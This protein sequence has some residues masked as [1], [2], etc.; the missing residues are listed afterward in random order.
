LSGQRLGIGSRDDFI[1]GSFMSL[2]IQRARRSLLTGFAA[3]AL[4]TGC[5]TSE[6]ERDNLVARAE[7]ARA[8]LFRQVPAAS[9]IAARSAGYLIFPSV[10]QGAFI[11]GAQYGNGVLFEDGKQAGFYNITGG[12]WGLQ[13]GAQNFSQAYFFTT[14]EALASFRRARGL[15]LGAGLDFAVANVG[16]SGAIS[17]STLQ[18]PVIVFVYG[19]Q[20]L[21]GGVNVVGQKITERTAP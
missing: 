17:T 2:S 10:T 1:E 14:P 20:G 6:A 4:L 21:F 18:K 15:E 8:E 19:Q 13:A 16:T 7:A 9:D 3:A 5:S 12:S 11:F